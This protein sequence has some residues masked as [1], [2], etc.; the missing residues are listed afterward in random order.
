MRI[1]VLTFSYSPVANARAV[2]W[3]ALAEE[4]VK[5]GHEVA[6]V[7]AWGPGLPTTERL[8]GVEVYRSGTRLIEQLRAKLARRRASDSASGA[9]ARAGNGWAVN[10]IWRT[11][12]WPDTSCLWFGPA[13]RQARAVQRQFQAE[14][15]ISVSPTFTAALVGM[16]LLSRLP[17]RPS[18]L[19]DLGDPFSFADEAPPN[20][21][22]LYRGLNHKVERRAFRQADVVTVTTEETRRLYTSAFPESSEKVHVIPPLAP[23]RLA[24]N[25]QT[26]DGAISFVYVGTLYRAIRNPDFLLALFRS[27]LERSRPALELHIYGDVQDCRGSFERYQ[28][29][30]GRNV[31][32]HGTV[33]RE[34]AVQAMQQA[35]VLVNIGNRTS[36]QLPSKLVDYAALGKPIL[37]IAS[38]PDD[39]S[40]RFLATY[41]RLLNVL[42]DGD[43]P[44]ED[45]ISRCEQFVEEALNQ[46]LSAVP[47]DW[48]RPYM[49]DSI[50]RDYLALIAKA[51]C[52]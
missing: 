51:P 36:Y 31:F 7:S 22:R 38:V 23:R 10:S 5:L 27:L 26:P 1:L 48:L 14:V 30:L 12:Y 35:S 29:L 20:N 6:V 40:A 37:N 4:W 32:V 41:P 2:R 34:R 9:A 25:E 33:S 24:S 17:R 45:Q 19:L 15:V 18:W 16:A 39:S 44:Q 28:Q 46:R 42:A 21:Y 43:I 47:E 50:A 13:F 49:I 52:R 11:I 8:N 3:S